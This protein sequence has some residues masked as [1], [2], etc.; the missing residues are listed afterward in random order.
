MWDS[1]CKKRGTIKASVKLAF[2]TNLRVSFENLNTGDAFVSRVANAFK[3]YVP[4]G[5]N[6]IEMFPD[7]VK[8]PSEFTILLY[9]HNHHIL[10]ELRRKWGR[11][12]NN[13]FLI[14]GD[15]VLHGL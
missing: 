13:I 7:V 2:L 15:V 6:L 11:C 9:L 4:S 10:R 3:N 8:D 14:G 12:L 1:K 5:F